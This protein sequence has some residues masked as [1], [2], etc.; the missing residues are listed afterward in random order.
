M[1]AAIHTG[2]NWQ[3]N[4]LTGKFLRV[5]VDKKLTMSQQYAFLAKKAYSVLGCVR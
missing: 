1:H 4:R 2:A 5:L 3:K